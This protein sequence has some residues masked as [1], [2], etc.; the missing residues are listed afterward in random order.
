DK[1]LSTVSKKVWE[2]SA[3]GI[4]RTEGLQNEEDLFIFK[5]QPGQG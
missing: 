5:L 2:I 4:E 1:A 3:A